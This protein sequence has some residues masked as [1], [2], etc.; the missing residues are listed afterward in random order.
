MSAM[1]GHRRVMPW[2]KTVLVLRQESGWSIIKAVS[3]SLYIFFNLVF[4]L[5]VPNFAGGYRKISR[6]SSSWIECWHVCIW[7][8]PRSVVAVKPG[9]A[10]RA[11]TLG[12]PLPPSA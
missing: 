9:A 5:V 12:R 1:R 2:G 10:S 6:K 11:R 3:V 7:Q 4:N 8:P